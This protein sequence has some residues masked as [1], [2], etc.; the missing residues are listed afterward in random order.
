[1]N[2]LSFSDHFFGQAKAAGAQS[3]VAL[4]R[5][6]LGTCAHLRL[7]AKRSLQ[8]SHDWQVAMLR[9]APILAPLQ[10]RAFS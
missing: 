7:C 8:Q 2:Q 5:G 9:R 3:M 6:Q 1:M 4:G 10:E